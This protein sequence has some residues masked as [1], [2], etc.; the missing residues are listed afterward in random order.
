MKKIKRIISKETDYAIRL[1]IKLIQ[2][3]KPVS[4]NYLSQNLYVNK[5]ML[6]KIIQ[7]LK[8]KNLILT[9]KGKMVV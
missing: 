3:N 6:I 1:L 7:M 9:K 8:T 2:L 4:I 5:P